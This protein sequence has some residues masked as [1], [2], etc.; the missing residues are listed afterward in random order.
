LNRNSNILIEGT[1]NFMPTIAIIGLSCV[2]LPLAVEFGKQYKVVGFDIDIIRI[3]EL[4]GGKDNTLE[5]S[6]DE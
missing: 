1:D 5:I 6:E 3:N 4:F 2:G